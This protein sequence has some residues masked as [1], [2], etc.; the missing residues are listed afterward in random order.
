MPHYKRCMAI[1]HKKCINF[2]VDLMMVVLLALWV[3]Q[4]QS[5]LH[6]QLQ[7][8]LINYLNK[9]ANRQREEYF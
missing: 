8:V 7:I 6:I 2:D 1:K 4:Y 9:L 3:I 5:R